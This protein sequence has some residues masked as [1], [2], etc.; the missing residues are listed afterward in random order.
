LEDAAQPHEVI[1]GDVVDAGAPAKS[2]PRKAAGAARNRQRAERAQA[3]TDPDEAE[4]RMALLDELDTLLAKGQVDKFAD[5]AIVV[6]ELGGLDK[7]PADAGEVTTEAAA[8]VIAKLRELDAGDRDLVK[9]L[10]DV[11][12]RWQSRQPGEAKT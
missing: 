1:D 12:N 3:A 7:A 11:F 5:M 6:A 9:A 10:D 4:A 2:E 8:A